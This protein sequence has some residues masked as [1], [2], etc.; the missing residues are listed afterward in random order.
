MNE[1][2]FDTL[3]DIKKSIA[4]FYKVPIRSRFIISNKIHRRLKELDEYVK[5]SK[6]NPI[7][8]YP[9]ER[10]IVDEKF[11]DNEYSKFEYYLDS[12][13]I[14]QFNFSIYNDI[15]LAA[16]KLTGVYDIVR[17]CREQN[18]KADDVYLKKYPTHVD[19]IAVFKKAVTS[20]EICFLYE[21]VESIAITAMDDIEFIIS[22][23]ILS[24]S[25]IRRLLLS[26]MILVQ[27]PIFSKRFENIRPRL[28]KLFN[29]QI[30]IAKHRRDEFII[31]RPF[32][33]TALK[34]YLKI[35]K[36]G[37]EEKLLNM[38]NNGDY[39][40]KGLIEG[41]I[42]IMEAVAIDE[43]VLDMYKNIRPINM[44]DK[45]ILEEHGFFP[46]IPKTYNNKDYYMHIKKGVQYN[47][48]SSILK[49]NTYYMFTRLPN[50]DVKSYKI[51]INN[52]KPAID[53]ITSAAMLES[54]FITDY[55]KMNR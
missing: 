27:M 7:L 12:G 2:K 47:L 25:H 53:K 19:L 5:V 17:F 18:N 16:D 22:T 55:K 21:F 38:D 32:N 1:F 31:N 46:I 3:D 10:F 20:I 11:D 48:Y 44:I 43:P 35:Q 6:E 36:M 39:E 52:N 26:P 8:N 41:S 42:N 28:T 33:D 40:P 29:T 37:Y 15:S 4:D 23:N 45:F 24:D 13:D 49:E 54:A 9:S 30:A 14:E 34:S 51:T 50:S